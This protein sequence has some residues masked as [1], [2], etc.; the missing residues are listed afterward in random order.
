M[1]IDFNGVPVSR[2]PFVYGEFDGSN[3]QQ[4]LDELPYTALII[5]QKTAT[6]SKPAVGVGTGQSWLVTSETQ[7]SQYFGAGSQLHRMAAAFLANNPSTRL[8]AVALDD[9]VAGVAATGTIAVS[10]TVTAAG[11]IALYV[12]GKKIEVGV[13][14]GNATTAIA[15]AIASAINAATYLPVTATAATS[16]VTLTAKNKGVAG[17][18]LNVLHSFADGETL[19]AGLTLT[20]SAMSGGTTTPDLANVWAAVEEDRYDIMAMP[21]TDAS[22]LTNAETELASRF[23][24][25]RQLDGLMI[26]AS[27][28]DL[29]TVGALGDSRNSPSL[30]IMTSYGSPTP[31]EEW[32]AAVAGVV[33]QSANLDPARPF[34]TLPVNYVQTPPKAARFTPNERNILLFDNISTHRVDA[35]G[36]AVLER[37][38]TTYKTN[39]MGAPDTAYL[40]ITTPL[41]LAYIRQ[42]FRN[43]ILR[44]FPRHKLAD[45]GATYGNGQAVVTPKVMKAEAVAWARQMQERGLIEGLEQFVDDLIVERNKDNRN[46]MDVLLPPDITNQLMITAVKI[47]FLL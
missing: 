13:A 36:K 10:G 5:G 8:E 34:Q 23:G 16:T 11:T 17:N 46:R 30:S 31:P 43:L 32:A 25:V 37:M 20:I 41:T 21:Y 44:K 45:D 35:S 33:A 18:F 24:P 29:G 40:D 6:G 4:G 7:A 9:V 1:A 19:P 14:V 3:A 22:S 15:S 2:V 38:L 12:A 47:G 27:S 42:T 39:S 26:V 28:G